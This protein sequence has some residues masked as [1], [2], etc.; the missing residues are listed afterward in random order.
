[1][2]QQ[3]LRRPYIV[4]AV[5]C[6]AVLLVAL[7]AME[8]LGSS[9]RR[10]LSQQASFKVA[11]IPEAF[12]KIRAS[13]VRGRVI[14]VFDRASRLQRFG[15]DAQLRRFTQPGSEVSVAPNELLQALIMSGVV[16]EAY[17][18]YPESIWAERKEAEASRPFTRVESDTVETRIG[19]ARVVFSAKPPVLAEKAIVF[20]NGAVASGYPRD[21]IQGYLD[22]NKSDIVVVLGGG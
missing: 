19:G 14:V 16:R 12:D 9:G 7:L 10:Y 22:P 5:A 15:T 18:V 20:T 17:V 8:I 21:M 13:G 11:T 1:L 4:A 6:L 3:Q 2:S